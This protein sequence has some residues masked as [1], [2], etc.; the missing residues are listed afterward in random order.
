MSQFESNPPTFGDPDFP[1]ASPGW[2]KI[3]GII[4]IVW[5]SLGLI[6]NGCGAVSPLFQSFMMQ[7]VPPEQ[8]AQ[9]QQQ[10]AGQN[11]AVT[12]AM[13]L[14]GL[15]LAGLLMFAAIQ[16]LRYRWKGRMLHLVWGVI[17]VV[18]AL[19]G[20]VVGWGQMKAQVA[21]QLQQMQS[22]PNTAAQAQQ[23]QGMVETTAYGMY[24]CMVFLSIAYP[25]FVLIWF[26]LI[27][28]REE[29]MGHPPQ[30]IVA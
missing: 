19:I 13:S 12:V 8:Q 23:M 4:S 2:P 14:V 11:P 7:M 16:T 24:G 17:S 9:M 5:A 18:V 26:G 10:A 27:K 6:C 1:P 25:I 30:E 15:L 22:D 21:G 29:Q 28:T 3:I 20:A